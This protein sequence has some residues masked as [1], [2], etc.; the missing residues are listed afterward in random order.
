ELFVLFADVFE[1]EYQELTPPYLA[2]LLSRAEFWAV[3]AMAGD[4]IVGGITAHCLPMTLSEESE[5]FIYDLAV[6]AEHQRKGIGRALVARLL[7]WA[8]VEG[9]RTAFV[10]ADNEDTHAL[11]FYRAV[12]GRES[13]VTIFLFP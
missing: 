8:A 6:R 3:A 13:A 5:L 12:G 2:R 11:D 9:I 7:D 10:P 4:H 1:Q